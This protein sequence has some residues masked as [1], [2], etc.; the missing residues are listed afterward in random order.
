MK[1]S[2]FLSR[3][4][5]EDADESHL[6]GYVA[7]SALH[8]RGL[9]QI[10]FPEDG[11]PVLLFNPDYAG[12]LRTNAKVRYVRRF[13]FCNHFGGQRPRPKTY[14]LNTEEEIFLCAQCAAKAG[15]ELNFPI[16]ESPYAEISSVKTEAE[17]RR[18]R[19][20]GIEI[21]LAFADRPFS[22]NAYHSRVSLLKPWLES[23]RGEFDRSIDDDNGIEFISPPLHNAKYALASIAY[24]MDKLREF[25]ARATERTGIHVHVDKNGLDPKAI[26]AFTT[27]MEEFVFAVGGNWMRYTNGR[28]APPM[29]NPG[30]HGG[31]YVAVNQ[32]RHTYE[33]RIFESASTLLGALIPVAITQGIAELA[34]RKLIPPLR[35]RKKDHV[36][37]VVMKQWEYWTEYAGWEKGGEW[38]GWMYNPDD[39][40]EKRVME[41]RVGNN[42][43]KFVLPGAD[44]IIDAMHQKVNDFTSSAGNG[45]IENAINGAW[46]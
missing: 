26:Y 31:H 11:N 46:R 41:V 27:V 19:K 40:E 13:P 8:F 36:A 37:D 25:G 32:A 44:E 28:Y 16:S 29:K 5:I 43:Y 30:R 24:M 7:K 1:L 35:I 23:W 42:M 14:V 39:D 12:P 10:V 45:S 33:I 34:Q 4:K 20:F 6:R 2:E 9:G 15:I 18:I 38:T 17:L 21:E 3:Y 22:P